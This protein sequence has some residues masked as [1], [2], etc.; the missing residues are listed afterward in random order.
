MATVNNA[1]IIGGG[2]GGL[3]AAIALRNA[4]IDVEL[5]EINKEWT[6]YHVGIVVQ[7]NAIRAMVALGIG[8]R[9]VAAGFP[10][11]GLEFRDLHDNLLADFHGVPLAGPNYPTDLGLTR[12]A[13][14]E[15]LS[16]TAAQ[17]GVKLRLGVTFSE[18]H[19]T[20]RNV[21]VRFTDGTAGEYDVVI[22][23][24]GVNSKVREHLFGAAR[25]PKYTGQGVWRYNVPRP[26][27]LTRARM[28]VGLDYGKC[29]FIPLTQDTGYVLLV[30]AEPESLRIPD[31]QLAPEFRK[32]LAR[33][34]GTMAKLRD[35]IVDS[36][37]VVYR[38]LRSLFMPAPWYRDRI[39]LLGD[40]VHATTPHMGQGAAQAMEDAVVL[41][42]LLARDEPVG[43]LFDE[44]VRRRYER[45][46]FVYDA[47]VQIGEWEQHP[48]S[49]ADP[50]GL[51][52]KLMKTL[53]API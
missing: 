48:S 25:K 15:V 19:S 47:S 40:A 37:M 45:C 41:G 2:I 17:L 8:E 21:Q 14:H 31:D 7:G 44:Y 22:G 26:P 33:C 16:S 49:E 27:E 6:V 43:Q 11:D 53:V 42:D 36:H 46:K 4:G 23:A 20:D 51:T 39:V 50:T 34:T 24:D 12:P 1:L 9:C 28:C 10:Y 29:G 3:S 38:P 52:A 18:L 13:L 35:Q 32:R 5:V 30:Q